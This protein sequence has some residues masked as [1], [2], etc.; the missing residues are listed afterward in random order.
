MKSH[1]T[2]II[3]KKTKKKNKTEALLKMLAFENHLENIVHQISYDFF[4]DFES[5]QI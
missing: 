5:T 4:S 1:K 3:K 2:I